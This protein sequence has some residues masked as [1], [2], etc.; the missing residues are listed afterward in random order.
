MKIILLLTLLVILANCSNELEIIHPSPDTPV[1][2][3]AIDLTSDHYYITLTHT[4]VGECSIFELLEDNPGAILYPEAEIRMEAIGTSGILWST[5]F[6]SDPAHKKPGVF[7]AVPGHLWVSDQVINDP[8]VYN[9]YTGPWKNLQSIRLTVKIP[10][11]DSIIWAI[12]DV[13]S[14]DGL[15]GVRDGWRVNFF[16]TEPIELSIGSDPDY[17]SKYRDLIMRLNYV[18]FFKY[19]TDTVKQEVLLRK[20]I[21]YPHPRQGTSV[22]IPPDFFLNKLRANVPFIDS[23]LHRRMMEFDLVVYSTSF[24]YS[25]Y[26]KVQQNIENQSA[27]QNWSNIEN[28]IGLFMIIGKSEKRNLKFHQETIDS[29]VRSDI[30]KHLKFQW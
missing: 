20:N 14:P 30:T 7:P 2:F 18:N 24:D 22:K 27:T 4:V 21:S 1:I 11:R 29:I 23:L 25:T 16:E 6:H 13:A 8:M 3:G 9:K 10:G 17:P 15:G 5:G 12:A 19:S 26:E 28:G